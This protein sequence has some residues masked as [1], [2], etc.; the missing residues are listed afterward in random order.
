MHNLSKETPYEK[1]S[2]E[3]VLDAVESLGFSCTGGLF[4]LNSYE[5]RV[6]DVAVEEGPNVVVKFYRPFR[7]SEE[8][9][10]EEHA[11]AFAL[12]GAEVPVVPPLKF[13]GKSLFEHEG[14]Q[15]SVYPKRGG[16]SIELKSDEDFRHMGRLIARIHNIGSWDT[17]QK[18]PSLTVKSMGW[19]NLVYLRESNLVP[20]DMMA[21][22]DAA[23]TQLLTR[24]DEIWDERQFN[25]RIHGDCHLGN[26]LEDKEIFFVDLDDSVAGPAIQDLWLFAN[27]DTPERTR[28][29]GLLVEGYQQI[30]EFDFSELQ[31]V[32][33][34]RALRMIHYTAW[35][36]R[37]WH[38]PTFPKAFPFFETQDY[39]QKH[40]QE[41]KEQLAAINEPV[42]VG[43]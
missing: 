12:E 28:Q 22:Y 24:L 37:R 3:L 33:V 36:A 25:L 4:A 23:V 41:L 6:Y 16:R 10:L 43:I 38:D 15:F 26:I 7:W 1:L 18:R 17:Y 39:W 11:F 14:Y 34:L 9:I 35:I 19:D 27:G 32:E 20:A 30:R 40:L 8:Q 29:M 2:P 5:N 31:L 13:E 21:A 42:L